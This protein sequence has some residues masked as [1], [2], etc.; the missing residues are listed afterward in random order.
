VLHA[1]EGLAP[2]EDGRL[3]APEA[4]RILHRAPV[5]VLV[6]RLVHVRGRSQSGGNRE[7]VLVHENRPRVRLKEAGG[8][9]ACRECRRSSGSGTRERRPVPTASSSIFMSTI[10]FV[11]SNNMGRPSDRPSRN[12]VPVIVD[13]LLA[14]AVG[15]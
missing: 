6:S 4:F 1:G 3:L 12:V 2:V 14:L 10:L 5:G 8:W 13:F 15:P 7:N 9:Q 11:M